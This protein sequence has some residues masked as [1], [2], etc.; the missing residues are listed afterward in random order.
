[1]ELYEII[2]K[3]RTRYKEWLNN[4]LSLK[5]I[6]MNITVSENADVNDPCWINN[7]FSG[8]DAIALYCFLCLKNPENYF[9]VGSG[10]STK[11]ARHAIKNYGLRTKITSFDPSPRAGIDDICDVI[12]REPLENVSLDIFDRLRTDDIFFVDNSHRVFMNSDSTVVFLDIL[13]K[14]KSGVLV[15]I[16][17]IFLPEDYPATWKERYYSEQYLLASYLLAKGNKFEIILPNYFI[18]KD[19]ELAKILDNI[20]DHPRM[21]GVEKHGISFWLRTT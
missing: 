10:N 20:W 17:D 2:N 6:F 21:N 4:F 1:M 15:Q 14:L 5:D 7:Y 18:S 13:P 11:F 9:E 16:H 19:P 8:L 12:L 3:N